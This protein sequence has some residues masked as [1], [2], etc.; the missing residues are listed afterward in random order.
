MQVIEE[1]RTR[2]V[3]LRAAIEEGLRTR[4]VALRA[5]IEEGG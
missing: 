3:A 4:E 1:L 5:A 2:E